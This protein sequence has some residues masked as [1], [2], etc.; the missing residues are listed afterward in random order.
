M[1]RRAGRPPPLNLADAEGWP[2]T[3]CDAAVPL[4]RGGCRK[5][6]RNPSW[7]R[8][9]RAHG[10]PSSSQEAWNRKAVARGAVATGS[11][12][13][14]ERPGE[15]Q[16]NREAHP[17]DPDNA[18]K[19][20]ARGERKARGALE[21][22]AESQCAMKARASGA[23]GGR[24]PQDPSEQREPRPATTPSNGGGATEGWDEPPR[25]H[26]QGSK[27][28]PAREA[29]VGAGATRRARACR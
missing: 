6:H 28:S 2:L 22:G 3:Q 11:P 27:Q 10:N 8:G 16:S 26:E 15:G 4:R 21:L 23:T 19:G 17:G 24:S 14:G 25:T 1:P 20:G 12:N 7:R 18:R 13:P 9:R 5:S 29:H